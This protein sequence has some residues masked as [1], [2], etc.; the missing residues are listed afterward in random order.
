ME[1]ITESRKADEAL[2]ESLDNLRKTLDGT[3]RAL[4]T[5]IELRDPYTAGHQRRVAQL[6]CAIAGQLG[7]TG[8]RLEGMQVIGFLHDIGKIVVPAEILSKP[9]ELSDLEF[10]MIK[11]HAEVGY[12][13]LKGIEFPWPVG[14]AVLQHHERLDGSGYPG[15]LKGEELILEAKI[16]AVADVVESMASHRPY[17]AA[18]GIDYALQEVSRHRG[19]LYDPAVVDACVTLLEDGGLMLQ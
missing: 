13:I 10:N 7:F 14:V 4:A 15:G 8:D 17:R 16:L 6:A 11:T 18:L 2:N 12:N 3:V 1:D 9:G 5:T 19:V